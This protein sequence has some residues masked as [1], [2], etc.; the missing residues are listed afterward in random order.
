MGIVTPALDTPGLRYRT[1]VAPRRQGAD[2][3]PEADDV[4]R[5][6]AVVERSVAKLPDVG[7][8][9]AL[10][11]AVA[12]EGAGVEIPGCDRCHAGETFHLDPRAGGDPLASDLAP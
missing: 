10:D 8:A 6:A 9:P 1:G 5:D 2:P 3:T 11:R 12:S 7:G 4:D